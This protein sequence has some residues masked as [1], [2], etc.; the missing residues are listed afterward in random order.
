M[1]KKGISPLIATVLLIGL[2]VAL[3]TS[4]IMWGRGIYEERKV[5]QG[6]LSEL[7]FD[8]SID[9]SFE[10]QSSEFS[11]N[12]LYARIE[13]TGKKDIDGFRVRILGSNEKYDVNETRIQI[14][15]STLSDVVIGYDRPLI[16][17]PVEA[18]FVPMFRVGIDQYVMCEDKGMTVNISPK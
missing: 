13:N 5:K 17:N 12:N 10:I 7:Q 3:S 11:A 18:T 4:V 14:P 16:G 15:K 1:K 6:T 9:I 2:T 8:C